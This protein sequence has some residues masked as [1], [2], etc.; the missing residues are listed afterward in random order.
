LKDITSM[1]SEGPLSGARTRAPRGASRRLS[2]LVLVAL[3]LCLG[4][5][6]SLGLSDMTASIAK[7]DTELP[8]NPEGLRTYTQAWEKRYDSRPNDK[9]T[10]LAF[11]RGLRALGHTEQAVAVVQK[12]ALKNPDDLEV[13][14]AY[15]KA[16][17]DAGR[18]SEAAEV[19]KQ[20][21]RPEK[22]NWSIL[23]AQGSVADQMGDHGSAQLFYREALKINPGE[24][25]I[26][27]NLGLSLALT[28]KLDQAEETLRLANAH[29][30]AD[31][32]VRQNLA[33]VLALQGKFT[34]AETISA[35]DVSPEQAAANV[36]TIRQMISQSNTWRDI[37]TRGERP[38]QPPAPPRQRAARVQDTEAEDA[39]TKAAAGTA[40]LRQTTQD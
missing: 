24:P 13:L 11:A 38:I 33:L 20:S 37:Q 25:A 30:R 17:A 7:P 32:R 10:A 2:L 23:S 26:L 3:P 5:C 28:K 14:S 16:L 39:W 22:P 15:G 21:H 18:L 1:I 34:E 9:E 19:L 40:R 4:G 8:S 36:T 31:A 6:K 27:S 29:P 35:R 12:L